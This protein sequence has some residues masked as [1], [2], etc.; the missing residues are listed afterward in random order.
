MK[1]KYIIVI[2]MI[3]ACLVASLLLTGCGLLGANG[4]GGT[5]GKDGKSAF[6]IFKEYHPEYE[7]TEEEWL[8]SLVSS[9]NG[10]GTVWFDGTAEPDA[11][12][13]TDAKNGDYYLRVFSDFSGKKGF[14]IYKLDG[15][16]WTL[17]VDMS[18]ELSQEEQQNVSEYHIRSLQDLKAFADSVNNGNNYA[19]KIVYLDKDIDLKGVENWQPIGSKEHYFAGTFNGNGH[20]ISNLTINAPDTNYVGFIGYLGGGKGEITNVKFENA[21]IT[22][23]EGCGVAVGTAFNYGKVSKITVQGATVKG[24]KDLGGIAGEGYMD[25]EECAVDGL[26]AIATP[27]DNDD[28]DK[29]GGIIG[30]LRD[31]N[32]TVKGCT[33]KNSQLTA[34]RDLGALVGCYDGANIVEKVTGNTVDEVTL[35]I[36]HTIDAG[37]SALNVRDV[38]GRTVGYSDADEAN[39][40]LKNNNTVGTVTVKY[41]GIEVDTGDKN[42]PEQPGVDGNQSKEENGEQAE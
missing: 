22:G 24:L 39:E 3:V 28:G 21:D 33:V 29:V 36:D 38:V 35:T 12:E 40:L 17:L 10:R 32:Y 1:R 4:S 30:Y 6:E 19:G 26:T 9:G 5:N 27:R 7:G 25:I 8:E 31:S 42:E 20:V 34:Y 14:S 2:S 23:R 37:S 41:V 11:E 16:N 18:E 13:L 15:D